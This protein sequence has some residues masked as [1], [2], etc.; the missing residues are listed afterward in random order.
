MR[1][2]LISITSCLLITAGFLTGAW[3]QVPKTPKNRLGVDVVN[4]ADGKRLYGVL[5]G[6]TDQGAAKMAIEREWLKRTHRDLYDSYRAAEITARKQ[7]TEQLAQRIDRWA[8]QRGG[9]AL[10]TTF[11]EDEK[12]RIQAEN[13]PT[14]SEPIFIIAVIPRDQ[15]RNVFVQPPERRKIV[16]LAWQNGL[17]SPT[18]T[19]T[20]QL[21]KRLEEKQVDI[22]NEPVNLVGELPAMPQTDKQWSAKVA[23]VEHVLRPP[24]EY[25]GT[26]TMLFRSGEQVDAGKM[27]GSLLGNQ[28][29]LARQLAGQLG[30]GN[31]P[32]AHDPDWWKTAREG[33]EREG[34]SGVFVIRM[35]QDL[36]SPEVKVD[37]HF[38]A[39]QQDGNWFEVTHLQSAT[40]INQVDGQA[41]QRLREEPQ[42]K[43]IFDTLGQ[44]GLPGG[45][46][47]VDL[48]LRHGAATQSSMAKLRDQFDQFLGSYT[49][50][51]DTPA[52]PVR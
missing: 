21:R 27:L 39:Q 18:T 5:L 2:S 42:V 33:A 4:L 28:N 9:D 52:V 19:S 43:Q 47:Q 31:R 35:T 7:S 25:Q 44:L 40:Q 41:L 13:T 16:G 14:G 48:A 34:Y 24:L 20:T 8:Q 32:P 3:A 10:L 50:Q 15:V 49:G 30:L 1:V 29:S 11:L 51:L 26:G 36:T 45:N 6:E 23:L 17:A 12:K 22:Q 46:A 38:F 37:G